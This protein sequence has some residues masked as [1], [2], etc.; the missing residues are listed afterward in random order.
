MQLAAYSLK[1]KLVS[2]AIQDPLFKGALGDAAKEIIEESKSAPNEATVESAF[3]RILYAVLKEIG[4]SFQPKKEI[5]IKTRRHTARGRT[6]SRIGALIIEYKQPSTLKSEM[7]IAKATAQLANYAE[8][9]AGELDNEIVGYLTDGTKILEV[10]ATQ[11]G[12]VTTSSLQAL[13]ATTLDRLVR[14]I[15]SL[16][17]SA[18]TAANLIRDFCGC[19]PKGRKAFEMR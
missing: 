17:K 4:I 10:R 12:A 14:S 2:Q 15:I 1:E 5:P 13:D 6:D 19:S 7:D 3:E 8:A 16:E 18:L 11:D 9:L